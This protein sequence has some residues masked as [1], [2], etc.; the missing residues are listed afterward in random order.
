[1]GG[2]VTDCICCLSDGAKNQQAATASA[3][4][5]V[6]RLGVGQVM[7]DLCPRHSELVNAAARH[8][9]NVTG[10]PVRCN[11]RWITTSAGS[12]CDRCGAE[13]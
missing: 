6:V 7:R 1:M 5:A 2:P 11:H 4:A 13:D 12:F 9:G 8:A 3:L 10:Y